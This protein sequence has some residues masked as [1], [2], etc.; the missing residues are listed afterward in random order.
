[1]PVTVP[2]AGYNRKTISFV[3]HMKRLDLEDSMASEAIRWEISNL[4]GSALEQLLVVAQQY[5]RFGL[6][7][8]DALHAAAADLE[9]LPA[10][11]LAVA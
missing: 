11:S 7:R 3:A 6:G 2:V 5:E 8:Q 1:M 4:H 9:H 10:E